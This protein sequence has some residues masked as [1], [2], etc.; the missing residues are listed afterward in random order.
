M[1]DVSSDQP[2]RADIEMELT[3]ATLRQ[4]RDSLEA[5]LANAK[6]SQWF[7]APWKHLV[8]LCAWIGVSMNDIQEEMRRRE[9]R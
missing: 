2:L 9:L 5:M 6:P 4:A 3:L 7:P 8:E 1:S